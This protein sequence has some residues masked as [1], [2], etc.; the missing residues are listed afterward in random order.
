MTDEELLE[1][2]KDRARETGKPV[3]LVIQEAIEEGL[4]E[5]YAR[6]PKWDFAWLLGHAKRI[7]R[8]NG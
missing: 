6:L 3:R 8:L 5:D 4:R 7:F 2:V 1:R